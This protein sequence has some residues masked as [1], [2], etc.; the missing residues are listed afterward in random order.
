MDYVGSNADTLT[1][2]RVVSTAVLGQYT[3]AY[4]LVF[5]PLSI[6]MS[7]A[8]TMCCSRP[9]AASSTIWPACAVPTS[10]SCRSGA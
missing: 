8:L 4:Y 9:S 7:Q 3:R 6:Y 5:Q 2:S 10:A 1:V